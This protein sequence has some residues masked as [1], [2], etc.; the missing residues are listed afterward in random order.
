VGELLVLA[1][2]VEENLENIYLEK[3]ILRPETQSQSEELRIKGLN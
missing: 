1:I 2:P 3:Q